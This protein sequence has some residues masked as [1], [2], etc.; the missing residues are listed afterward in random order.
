MPTPK[1]TEY[2]DTDLRALQKHAF[3]YFPENTNPENGLVADQS[4]RES[5]C[6]IAVLGFALSCYPVAVENGWMKRSAAQKLALA[7]LRF[8][9]ESEQSTSPHATGHRGF[10]YHFLDM[11]S[12]R[13]V[14]KCELSTI[15]STLLFYGI[16]TA[17]AYFDNAELRE[18]AE[19]LT[20]RADWHWAQNQSTRVALSWKPERGF[21]KAR[22]GGYNEGLLLQILGLGASKYTLP[23]ENYAVWCSSYQWRKIYDIEYLYAGPLF[24]HQFPHLWL[25]LRNLRDEWMQNKDCNYFENSR[26]AI[27]V[28]R[29]YCRRNPHKFKGYDENCWGLTAGDGP[30]KVVKNINGKRIRF[31]DYH[32]RG[33]PFGG[34][35]GTLSPSAIAASL[36][37]APDET[38]AALHHV[39][40]TYPHLIEGCGFRCS[41]NPTWGGA[42]DAGWIAPHCFGLDQGPIVLAF[43]NH[44]S[45]LIWN[46]TRANKVLQCGLER[47][48]FVSIEPQRRGDAENYKR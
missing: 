19:L 24:I 16:L 2:S 33:V 44:L 17:A 47:A 36:P 14:W 31:W 9:C 30:D 34:D 11:P 37:F 35:D 6:S 43:E 40:S 45:G 41:F 39:E 3:D 25:D 10:Y 27:S 23:I 42:T 8:L 20:S 32:A 18:R 12:G 4:H 15:D 28:Q 7:A 26:R 21:L 13:R 5:P 48:G 29:E 38:R 22:W 1:L 46:L